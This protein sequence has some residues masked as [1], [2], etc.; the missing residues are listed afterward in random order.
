MQKKHMHLFGCL[1]L[2]FSLLIPATPNG[3]FAR[4]HH[5][6]K[7]LSSLKSES[8]K[9]KSTDQ[10]ETTE[11]SSKKPLPGGDK[12][13][14]AV[15]KASYYSNRFHKKKTADGRHF[16]KT[17]FTAAHRSLP[18]GTIVRVTNLNNGRMVFVTINDRGPFIK[19]RIIDLSKAAAMQLG[20]VDDGIGHVRIEAYN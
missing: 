7:Q 9:V 13:L 14:V 11:I 10:H 17:D 12:F 19:N 15:G 1:A 6:K 8:A 20:L 16:D 18:F 2:A 3:A 4:Q 5:T